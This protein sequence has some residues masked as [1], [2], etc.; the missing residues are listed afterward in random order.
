MLLLSAYTQTE[1]ALL[2]KRIPVGAKEESW[3]SAEEILKSIL[4]YSESTKSKIVVYVCALFVCF[5][6]GLLICCWFVHFLP[7]TRL[8]HPCLKML[9]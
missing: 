6:S 8:M 5:D 7:I 1:V 4:R 3:V 9:M 2:Q